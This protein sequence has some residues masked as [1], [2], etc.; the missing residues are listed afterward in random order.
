MFL[1]VPIFAG[2]TWI[3]TD[4]YI[5]ALS[6]GKGGA[7]TIHATIVVF[8][9]LFIFSALSDEMVF[10]GHIKKIYRAC[11]II[12]GMMFYLFLG[13]VFLSVLFLILPSVSSTVAWAVTGLCIL[14]SIIG[15]FQARLFSITQY[16]VSLPGAPSPW[17]NKRAVFLSDTHFGIMNHKQFSEKIV[18]R[19]LE[20]APDMVFHGGDFYDGPT[21]DTTAITD[22]WK[23]LT[24]KVPVFYTSGN[25]EAY[26]P[27]ETFI[28]SIREAGVTVLLDEKIT[29]DGV[30]IAGITYRSKGK[31][32]QV[33]QVL[34]A[35]ALEKDVATIL[36]NHPPTFHSS[37]KSVATNVMLSG[38]THRGQFSPVGLLTWLIYGKY[39]Y[40]MVTSENMT[41]ITSRGVGTAGPPM[42]LFNTPELVVIT[43]KTS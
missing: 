17:N 41:A 21:V 39:N 5:E 32:A 38:H 40:G 24:E 18:S 37:A 34:N 28:T 4:V 7:H 13:S 31:N 20:L 14:L 33:Q 19:V 43:F 3:S 2:L 35:L 8:W 22:S 27:Y 30:Q 26:G 10:A 23:T 1:I 29:H 6:I 25:H 16:T 36:I 11:N 15:L 9:I 42:R 12:F